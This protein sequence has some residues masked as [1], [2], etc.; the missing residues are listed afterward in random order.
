[1]KNYLIILILSILFQGE[2]IEK[3][4]GTFED[5]R[6]GR[7]YTTV[8]IGQQVW[9]AENLKAEKFVNGDI[10]TNA[11]SESEWWKVSNEKKPAWC[12]YNN[13][14][15]N[16]EVHGKLY[17]WWVVD[18]RRKICPQGWK[19]PTKNDW[20]ILAEQIGGKKTGGKML[21]SKNNWLQN[22]NGLD[23]YGFSAQPSG[24]RY[25]NKKSQFTEG[26]DLLIGRVAVWW[27]SDKA[28]EFN[29]RTAS[30]HYDRE[31]MSIGIGGERRNA[32]CIR[33]IKE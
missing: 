29:A 9:M 16:E 19:V 28:G 17:N 30:M 11:V 1:M 12:H 14:A 6:D 31:N 21:K 26:D 22:G 33:C 2:A 7:V 20:D 13:E 15:S 5:P 3:E 18:D 23:S 8:K 25:T 32:Y 10:I 4:F 27:T 24:Y